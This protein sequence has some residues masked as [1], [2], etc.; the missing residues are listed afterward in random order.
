MKKII[1]FFIKTMN[2]NESSKK[3]ITEESFKGIYDEFKT[4]FNIKSNEKLIKFLRSIN[5]D[6]KN[7]CAKIL[8]K[9][10]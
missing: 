8:S 9:S 3:P 7:V 5:I 4:I 6:N 10:I 1:D 2:P